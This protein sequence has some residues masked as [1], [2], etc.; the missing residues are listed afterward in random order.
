MYLVDKKYHTV[1]STIATNH[2]LTLQR[3]LELVD[4]QTVEDEEVPS[5]S[6]HGAVFPIEDLDV[7]ARLY[8]RWVRFNWDAHRITD[9]ADIPQDSDEEREFALEWLLTEEELESGAGEWDED[10]YNIMTANGLESL[11]PIEVWEFPYL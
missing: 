2:S 4:A 1:I 7:V 3:A 9:E 10:G 6:I 11:Q 5:V 8:N